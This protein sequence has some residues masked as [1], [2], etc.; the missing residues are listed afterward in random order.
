MEKESRDSNSYQGQIHKL[1]KDLMV[2]WYTELDRAEENGQLAVYMMV[3]GNCVELLRAF[4]ILPVYP[5]INA[6]QLAIRNQS[7]APLLKSE[8]LGYATDNCGYVKADVGAYMMGNKTSMG[9]RLPKPALILCNYV[10]CNTYIKWFEHLSELM[11]VPIYLLDI[12]FVRNGEPS[13]QDILYVVRQLKELIG[14]LERLTG[15]KLDPERLKYCVTRAREAEEY[16]SQVKH[17]AKCKPSPFDAYFD[18][19]T[20][21]GPLYVYRGS[22]E[23]VKFFHAALQELEE[24]VRGGI[25]TVPSE[26]FRIVVEGPP[27]YPHFRVFRDMLAHWGACAVASTYSTVGGIWEF[28]FRHDP[29]HPLESIAEHMLSHNAANRNFLQRYAQLRRYVEEYSADALLIHSVKSCRLFSAGQGDMREYFTKDL[30]IPT[31]FVESDLED[32]RYFSPAQMRNRVDAFFE[33][34]EHR[35]YF[36]SPT[37]GGAA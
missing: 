30:K 17:Y 22:E 36:K 25:G 2:R 28:G 19:T 1:Q 29:D 9:T 26:K 11:K 8:E 15:K 35:K 13:L 4:E 18:S 14:L 16:W 37:V 24:R 34:L 23:C 32:P 20:M 31:L 33:S 12:P 21:M 7:L 3:S 27:P 5:E 6:L 10:G